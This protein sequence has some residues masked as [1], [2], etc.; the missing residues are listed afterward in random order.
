MTLLLI[1]PLIRIAGL[2]GAVLTTVSVMYLGKGMMLWKIRKMMETSWGAFLPWGKLAGT[3]FLAV[4]VFL[5][6][7]FLRQT[8]SISP[9]TAL[10]FDTLFYWTVYG[11]FLLWTPLLPLSA[12]EQIFA[13]AGRLHQALGG[14]KNRVKREAW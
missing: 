3:L 6:A 13:A 12:R 7:V 10:I 4:S 9:F 14:T 2:T 5:P 8:L 1:I 11:V